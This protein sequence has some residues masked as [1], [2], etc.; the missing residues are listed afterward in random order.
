MQKE[1][2]INYLPKK[3][4]KALYFVEFKLI[5]NVSKQKKLDHKTRSEQKRM[6]H[7]A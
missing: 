2:E 3:K 5:M 4:K 1:L 6:F 7:F